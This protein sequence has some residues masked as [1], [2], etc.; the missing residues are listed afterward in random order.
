LTAD[1]A[2]VTEVHLSLASLDSEALGDVMVMRDS[3]M[4]FFS[5]GLTSREVSWPEY[6]LLPK[7]TYTYKAY[8]LSGTARIDSSSL[9]PV[10]TMDTTSHNFT[11]QVY[12]LGSLGSTISDVAIVNDTSA[13]AV[14]EIYNYDSVGQPYPTLYNAARWNGR[15]WQL[16]EVPAQTFGGSIQTQVALT[17]VF[18]FGE[19]DI[20]TFSS[21]GSYSHW[22]GSQW[23]T[24]YVPERSGGGLKLWGT[25]SSSLYLTGTNGST[26]YYNGSSWQKLESGTTLDIQDIS[27]STNSKTG[28][29]EIIAVASKPDA[30]RDRKILQISGTTVTTLSDS[31]II[32]PWLGT[33]SSVSGVW[34]A[35]G[36][37]Y[38]VVGDG[39]FTKSN[40]Y[41]SG[42]WSTNVASYFDVTLYNYAVR[43]NGLND[44]VIVRDE[45]DILHFNGY[46]WKRF[47]QP[48]DRVYRSVAMRGDMVVAV[49]DKYGAAGVIAIGQR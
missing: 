3:V 11:W 6:W 15:S 19:S 42:Y 18:A 2:E 7:H 32:S 31:G 13:W 24:A 5:R 44:L 14:G 12:T 26:S 33:P 46:S 30:N 22:N 17:T 34:F 8:R 43:G 4:T 41:G 28:E 10:T 37:K 1:E 48:T 29:L 20:W 23:Q 38:Y 27:G 40:P 45:G 16:L 35:P 47:V 25:S 39:I 9:L 36:R 21:A 49:G